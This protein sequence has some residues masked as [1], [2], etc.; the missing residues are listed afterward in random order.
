[1]CAEWGAAVSG[2]SPRTEVSRAESSCVGP[3]RAGLAPAGGST[4]SLPVSLIFNQHA[5]WRRTGRR[6]AEDSL[7]PPRG[8]GR[9][10][11]CRRLCT[12]ALCGCELCACRCHT[13]CPVTCPLALQAATCPA[14]LKP[15]CWTSTTSR[16]HP[17]RGEGRPSAPPA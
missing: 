6:Q 3:L 13:L 14:T 4:H 5:M 16:G 7:R 10:P 12:R 11:I 2:L 15:S 17:C 1:M 8:P 9:L